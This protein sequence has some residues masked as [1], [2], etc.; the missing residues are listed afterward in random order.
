MRVL[1]IEWETKHGDNNKGFIYGIS[2]LE[3][4]SYYIEWFKTKEER[5]Q[6]SKENKF[7]VL[8]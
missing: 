4:F 1:F 6:Y 7:E 3:D 5:E 2:D 8:E